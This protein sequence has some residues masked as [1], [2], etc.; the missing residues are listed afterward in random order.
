MKTRNGFVSN[1]S[2]S[3]FIILLDHKPKT[4]EA[5]KKMMFPKYSWDETIDGYEDT[6]TSKGVTI[7]TIVDRVF[8]DICDGQKK[9][10]N[11]D[12]L[13]NVLFGHIPE[14]DGDNSI[15]HLYYERWREISDEECKLYRDLYEKYGDDKE[16]WKKDRRYSKYVNALE[17]TQKARDE[18]GNIRLKEAQKWYNDFRK[19]YKYHK[20]ECILE[21]G[22]RYKGETALE[23][24]NIFRNIPHLKISNH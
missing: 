2:S 16:K 20:F 6:P 12:R 1:S 13:E 18:W 10:L 15:T 22:D 23:H 3:S 14:I 8:K 21:Y 11:N 19:A 9:K 17:Q 7:R 5:L 4:T 24:G